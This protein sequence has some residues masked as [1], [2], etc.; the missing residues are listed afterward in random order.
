MRFSNS[1]G[2]LR[3]IRTDQAVRCCGGASKWLARR[4]TNKGWKTSEEERFHYKWF[5]EVAVPAPNRNA[6]PLFSV[7]APDKPIRVVAFGDF[8]TG[9]A[10][11]MNGGDLYVL[12][13]CT[14]PHHL[15]SF[16]A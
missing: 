4:A 5:C 3:Q 2:S 16:P 11:M 12:A 10:L 13:T 1:M 6:A 14:R 8:G 15:G 7:A 9:P